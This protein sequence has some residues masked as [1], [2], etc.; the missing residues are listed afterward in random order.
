MKRI[1]KTSI[2]AVS[3]LLM[4]S[5]RNTASA[6]FSASI[7]FQTFYDDLSP[8]GHWIDYPQYGYVWNPNVGADFR[9][10]S[11]MGHWEWSDEYDWIWVSDYDWGWAPFHYGRW[12]FD[13]VY[14]WLWVPGYDWSPAWVAWRSGGDF[15]GWAPINPGIDINISIGS[16]EP[17]IDYWCFAPRRYIT[18]PR[19]YDYCVNPRMNLTIVNNTT[20]INNYYGGRGRNIYV[21]GPRRDEVE[22]FTHERIRPVVFRD[23]DRPGRSEFRGNSISMYRPRVERNDNNHF[24]PRNFDR[25]NSRPQ[26]NNGIRRE[27]NAFDRGNNIPQRNDRVNNDRTWQNN[28]HNNNSETQQR[29]N[30]GIF[31]QRRNTIPQRNDQNQTNPIERRQQQFQNNDRNADRGNFDDRNNNRTNNNRNSNLFERKPQT[32]QDNNRNFGNR[33]NSQPRQIQQPRQF[34]R[35][36]E[37]NRGQGNG[38]SNRGGGGR[39]KG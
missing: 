26:A 5:V 19:I 30:R 18:S 29:N 9:P 11:T 2:I 15:Y 39:R 4:T 33:N 7:S 24:A 28:N 36:D 35:R 20:I 23:S 17:P 31:D 3:I 8:Y 13:P 21:N 12:F 27:N 6:Q 32:N 34:E 37:G 22:R 25:F 38:N 10:Y 1:F 14:G 16:Y